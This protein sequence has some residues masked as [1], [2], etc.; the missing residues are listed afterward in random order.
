MEGVSK[1]F[2]P[3]LL[4]DDDRMNVLYAPFRDKSINPIGY[5]SKL[6]AWQDAIKNY[7]RSEKTAVIEVEQLTRAFSFK[8]KKPRCLDQV[9]IESIRANQLILE[10]DYR[11]SLQPDQ[12]GWVPWAVGLGFEYLVKKPVSATFNWAWSSLV[13]EGKKEIREPIVHREMIEELSEKLYQKCAEPSCREKMQRESGTLSNVSSVEN[14]VEYDILRRETQSIVA[15]EKTLF[16]VLTFLQSQGKL[17]LSHVSCGDAEKTW[18]IFDGDSPSKNPTPPKSSSSLFA[19]S[20]KNQVKKELTEREK[21]LLQLE[22]TTKELTRQIHAIHAEMA[23]RQEEA[24]RH[25]AAGIRPLALNALKRKKLLQAKLEA[26]EKSLDNIEVMKSKLQ[27]VDSAKMVVSAYKDAVAALNKSLSENDVDSIEET[28]DEM[29]DAL[30]RQAEVEEALSGKILRDEEDED[31]LEFELEQILN[32]SD[33]E[34]KVV[35]PEVPTD[36]IGDLLDQLCI[37]PMKQEI[38]GRDV[39]PKPQMAL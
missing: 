26:R 25:L 12:R 1:Y 19:T 7:M 39:A 20:V 16:I 18:V 24:K 8:D 14:A 3:D 17:G 22:A 2:P 28:M 9:L 5:E 30:D 23:E 37:S 15:D 11:A 36:D 32:E 38:G 33:G 31:E 34:A 35:L 4:D 27:D 13:G 6:N 10:S 21:T 29:R